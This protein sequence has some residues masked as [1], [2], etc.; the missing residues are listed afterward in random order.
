MQNGVGEQP[1]V[2]VCASSACTDGM[3]WE[4]R[5]RGRCAGAGFSFFSACYGGSGSVPI[6]VD[7]VV[8]GLMLR[9]ALSCF[10]LMDVYH[11]SVLG[12]R[13]RIRAPPLYS[14]SALKADSSEQGKERDR[15]RERHTH[16]RLVADG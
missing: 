2:C 14:A 4:G 1:H 16:T 13:T 7:F 10:S 5:G 3:G 15:D 8:I 11:L 9:L 6:V 12:T